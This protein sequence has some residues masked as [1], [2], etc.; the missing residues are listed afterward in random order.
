MRLT[1]SQAQYIAQRIRAAM[2]EGSRI[3]L[4]GSRADDTRRGGDVGLYVEPTHAVGLADELRTQSD[5]ADHL[6][7]D[8]DL[9]VARGEPGSRPIHR[10][11][12]STGVPL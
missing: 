9:I 2:G 10:I 4:F 11:A 12:R 5:L 7:L 6:D 1:E 3:W 8:V